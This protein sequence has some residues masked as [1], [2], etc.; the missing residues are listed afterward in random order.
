MEL[1]SNHKVV[2]TACRRKNLE[3]N[4]ELETLRSKH[5]TLTNEAQVLHARVSEKSGATAASLELE[6]AQAEVV[7]LQQRLV[8]TQTEVW[9]LSFMQVFFY[10]TTTNFCWLCSLV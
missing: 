2:L 9:F 8:L 1:E 4:T 3:L 5:T 6:H 7:K 10:F